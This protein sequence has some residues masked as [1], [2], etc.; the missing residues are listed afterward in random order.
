MEADP[1]YVR[2]LEDLPI[3][4][5]KAYLYG[6]WNIFSGLA[7]T[8]LQRHVHVIKPFELP[9]HT[10]YFGGYDWG[11]RHPFAFTLCAITVDKKIYVVGHVGSKG[12]LPPEQAE[13]IKRLVGDKDIRI[14][15][16]P[17][18]YALRGSIKVI[19]ELRATAPQYSWVRAN[20]DRVQG[21]QTLRKLFAYEG[22]KT[23]IPQLQF[24]ENTEPVFDQIASMQYDDRR[25][26]DVVK[27]DADDFGYGGDDLYDCLR[28]NLHTH[29]HPPKSP[30]KPKDINSGSYILDQIAE[31]ERAE[32]AA[33]IYI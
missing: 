19:D 30:A 22:T 11:Y 31:A 6:D 15:C 33:R 8:E 25:P 21:V 17:D 7:F 23:G 3:H 1:E 2:R 24:F 9:P 26:E 16:S 29:L 20:D 14:Y 12:K 18:A 13:M 5:K 32:R 28:Y 4:L 27:V 10:K